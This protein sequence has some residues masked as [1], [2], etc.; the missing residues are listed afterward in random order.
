MKQEWQSLGCDFR[1]HT[2][3]LEDSLQYHPPIYHHDYVPNGIFHLGFATK[4]L[5]AFLVSSVDETKDKAKTEDI[6][7]A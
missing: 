7:I 6:L 5:H 2:V 3:F 1:D 4:I